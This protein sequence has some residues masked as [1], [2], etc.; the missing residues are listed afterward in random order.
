MYNF[1]QNR[2]VY[3]LS[4]IQRRW[5]GR[6][7]V[8]FAQ[9]VCKNSLIKDCFQK[10]TFFELPITQ[11]RKK[12]LNC[13]SNVF[14]LFCINQSFKDIFDNIK[15]ATLK[16]FKLRFAEIKIFYTGYFIFDRRK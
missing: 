8:R 4:A 6:K 11:K 1:P 15:K 2:T 14:C 7:E 13:F 3:E 5:S 9:K 16:S 12:F 10:S